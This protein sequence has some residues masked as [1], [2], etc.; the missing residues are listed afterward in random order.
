MIHAVRC[1]NPRFNTVYFKQGFNIILAD[2]TSQSSVKDSRNGLGKSLLIEIIHFC[3][4]ASKTGSR[5]FSK[6]IFQQ[7]KDWTFILDFEL[8]G[9]AISASRQVSN[10]KTITINN[11]T[12]S[13]SES[14]WNDF[15]GKK[16]FG[17]PT[18]VNAY[19]PSFRN[20]ISYF[21]RREDFSFT[22]PFEYFSK[23]PEWSKQV[24]NTFLLG[25]AD[26]YA[27]KWQE[28]KDKKKLLRQLK[29][30]AKAGLING[31]L[32]S[33]G[34]LESERIRL[35]AEIEKNRQQLDSFQVHPQYKDI[36]QQANVLTKEIH[37]L[38]NANMSDRQILDL[39]KETINTEQ[40]QEPTAE[41]GI[42][43]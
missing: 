23:Q 1:S 18:K 41:S 33:L 21:I 40:T 43:N 36:E 14:E 37:Q 26:N 31:M 9:Q 38:S 30:A 12:K 24:H 7:V 16:M 42:V 27:S 17:L 29:K 3:L 34:E 4:G 2:K 28:I 15:L 35:Q 25:L 13:F 6:D 32:G 8:E 20:L 10:P 11:E 22:H 5:L 19:S 39:Y